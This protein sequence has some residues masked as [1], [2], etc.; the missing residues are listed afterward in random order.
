MQGST[1]TCWPCFL[2]SVANG[3]IQQMSLIHLNLVFGTKVNSISLNDQGHIIH[4]MLRPKWIPISCVAPQSPYGS[5]EKQCTKP[6]LGDGQSPTLTSWQELSVVT[7]RSLLSRSKPSWN[8]SC[9]G[10]RPGLTHCHSVVM[11]RARY[12]ETNPAL[13]LVWMG[14]QKSRGLIIPTMY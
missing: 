4:F 2:A 8:P 3:D 6:Q 11:H 13:N 1:A 5:G 14:N 12:E 10:S 9:S 7:E